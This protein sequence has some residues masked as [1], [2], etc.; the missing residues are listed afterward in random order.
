MFLVKDRLDFLWFFLG[1]SGMMVVALVNWVCFF[2]LGSFLKRRLNKMDTLNKPQKQQTNKQHPFVFSRENVW[3]LGL[4]SSCPPDK[5]R[6]KTGGWNPSPSCLSPL[7]GDV[8]NF[9]PPLK[10]TLSHRNGTPLKI[11]L[12]MEQNNC[13]KIYLQRTMAMFHC[14]VSLQEGI[15]TSD[16]LHIC[17]DL[18][19]N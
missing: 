10:G 16:E 11:K 4:Q 18:R 7:Q 13:L 17:K 15:L 6:C 5:H 9:T 14:H 19:K 2:E 8:Q 3:N 12:A 1:G